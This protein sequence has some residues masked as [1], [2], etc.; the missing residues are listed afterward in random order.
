MRAW[1]IPK[2]LWHSS[3]YKPTVFHKTKKKKRNDK[4]EKKER[5]KE[6]EKEKRK[7]IYFD[8][9]FLR[10]C[11]LLSYQKSQVSKDFFQLIFHFWFGQRPLNYAIFRYSPRVKVI[12]ESGKL[13]PVTGFFGDGRK[14]SQYFRSFQTEISSLF[15][16]TFK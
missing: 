2:A 5:K 9:T 11:L 15:R 7:K 6:R 4:K 3:F 14:K 10:D 8:G 13:S 1:F 12:K 16:N